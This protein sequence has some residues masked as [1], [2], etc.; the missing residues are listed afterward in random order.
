M[1]N[2]IGVAWDFAAPN[3]LDAAAASS[4]PVPSDA[5]SESKVG[6]PNQRQ[7]DEQPQREQD[8][9]KTNGQIFS[10]VDKY[11]EVSGYQ[12]VCVHSISEYVVCFGINVRTP[13]RRLIKRSSM[14]CLIA[15]TVNSFV[16][17]LAASVTLHT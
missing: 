6:D 1:W 3:A 8:P 2:K 17:A 13:S 4:P 16:S 5:P 12:L 11:S 7:P 9:T 15:S 10:W 14:T